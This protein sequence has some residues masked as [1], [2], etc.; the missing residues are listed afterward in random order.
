MICFPVLSSV[1]VSAVQKRH[2]VAAPAP[3]KKTLS[4]DD[5]AH[6]RSFWLLLSQRIPVKND[7]NASV[8]AKEQELTR[9]IWSVKVFEGLGEMMG[10]TDGGIVAYDRSPHRLAKVF[11]MQCDLVITAF[12]REQ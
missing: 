6:L 5:G 4:P 8:A 10:R 3:A 12:I 11:R 7:I 2:S 1:A 9:M